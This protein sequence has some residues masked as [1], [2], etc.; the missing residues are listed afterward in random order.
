VSAVQPFLFGDTW[1]PV[2]DGN[3]S[4]RAIFHRHYS[5]KPYRDGR[6]PLLFTGPGGKLVLLWPDA[7]A[8]FVWRRFISGDGQTGIN[9]AVFRNEGDVRS[10]D[11]IRA[12]DAI[13][14]HRWPGERHYTYVNTR[15][16]RSTNP[17]FCFQMAGWRRCGITKHNKLVILERMP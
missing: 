15:K 3:D 8:L 13:A 4:A 5:W 6:K 16:I 10:S 7:R 11:L 1:I 2:L 14:D 17:G 9:C 12:A